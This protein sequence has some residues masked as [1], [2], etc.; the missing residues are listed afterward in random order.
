MQSGLRIGSVF[1]IPL[2]IHP[3][4]LIIL[5]LLTISNGSGWE[6]DYPNWGTPIA[7]GVGFLAAILLFV[8]V[9][10][11]E[12]GH[13]LTAMGQGIQVNSITLFLFGG[14]ASIDRESKTP[15]K[16]FWVAIAGPAVSIALALV[17]FGLTHV[18]PLD[19][20]AQ[21]LTGDLARINFVLALFNLIPG[22]P[23]DGG[24]VLKAAVWKATGDR[25]K[26]VRW[27]SRS[28][29]ILGWGAVLLGLA[30]VFLLKEP[31]GF[32]MTL[33]GWFGIQNAQSYTRLTTLQE[34]LIKTKAQDA[35]TRQ[36][37]VLDG[38]LNVEA[39]IE[40]YFQASSQASS[41]GSGQ[42]SGQM[43]VQG[44]GQGTGQANQPYFSSTDG[45]YDGA[46]AIASIQSL[47]RSQWRSRRLQEFATPLGDIPTVTEAT[48]ALEV[49]Q[50]METE[51]LPYITVLSPAGAVA[52]VI[53]RGDLVAAVAKTL[54]IQFPSEEIARVKRDGV[55]PPKFQLGAIAQATDL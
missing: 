24:Q 41:Q 7:W 23:L 8:S 35:M 33:L 48:T 2:Q 21:V 47:E 1:G 5:A 25:F 51:S 18:L 44:T 9:L 17:L 28:G 55:Y 20:P 15:G 4:W 13:S 22:L 11:H 54:G 27:A 40:L 3:S 31:G 16:A 42:G 12:L 46:L 50:R 14:V 52:G 10:L 36:F 29:L 37:R 53:D 19:T 34:S 49:I 43:S 39:L 26:A 32:W 6:I 45:R 30:T 38:T